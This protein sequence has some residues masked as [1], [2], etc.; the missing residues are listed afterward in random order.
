MVNRVCEMAVLGKG[1]CVP[2]KH[3]G[4]KAIEVFLG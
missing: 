2:N 4:D 3:V 1:L